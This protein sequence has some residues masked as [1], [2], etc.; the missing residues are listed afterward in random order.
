MVGVELPARNKVISGTLHTI[1]AAGATYK[2]GVG[3]GSYNLVTPELS[4]G[5]ADRQFQLLKGAEEDQVV[6]KVIMAAAVNPIHWGSPTLWTQV[7]G[8][9]KLLTTCVTSI[10]T[11][12]QRNIVVNLLNAVRIRWDDKDGVLYTTKLEFQ[13]E[14]NTY[15]HEHC[16]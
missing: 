11:V 2:H 8:K 14:S 3:K 12:F 4:I 10:P 5:P 1:L 9:E 15:I 7:V 16:L 6:T 13:I